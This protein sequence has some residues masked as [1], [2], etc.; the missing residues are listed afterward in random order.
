VALA[1]FARLERLNAALAKDGNGFRYA[2][3]KNC[4]MADANRSI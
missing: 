2:F 4:L 1:A 3:V